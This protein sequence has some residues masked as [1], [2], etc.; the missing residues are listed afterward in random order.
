MN[1]WSIQVHVYVVNY[2]KIMY[3]TEFNIDKNRNC[4]DQ[5]MI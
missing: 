1:Y 4:T 5:Q 3:K 2:S